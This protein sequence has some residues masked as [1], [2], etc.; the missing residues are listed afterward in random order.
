MNHTQVKS[1][2]CGCIVTW[3]CYQL[4]AK[5]GNKIATVPWTDSHMYNHSDLV[6][7]FNCTCLHLRDVPISTQSVIVLINWHHWLILNILLNSKLEICWKWHTHVNQFLTNQSCIA[8]MPSA[9]FCSENSLIM[10]IGVKRDP[11]NQN[12]AWKIISEMAQVDHVGVPWQ[13]PT[14]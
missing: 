6:Y 14:L 12:C 9:K 7:I 13:L 11:P 5:P 2:N 10:S 4:I 1:Q 8:V 3:F